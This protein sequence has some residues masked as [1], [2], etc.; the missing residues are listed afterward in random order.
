MR[1]GVAAPCVSICV[2]TYNFGRYLGS[3]IRSVLEQT[4]A[5]W[6]LIVCDNASTDDSEAVASQWRDPRIRY[7]RYR[8]T[9]PMIHNFNRCL[10]RV[11]GEYVLF[12]CADDALMPT[13]IARLVDALRCHPTA[14][15]AVA[16]RRQDIDDAGEPV[17][18]L[19][20]H[21]LGPGLVRGEEVLAAQCREWVT[22]GLP[23]QVLARTSAVLACGGLDP[24]AT[25]SADNDLFSRICITWDAVYVDEATFLY[26]QHDA[27]ATRRHRRLL[28]DIRS[29]SYVFA[30]LFREAPSLRGNRE[31][32]RAF[33]RRVHPWFRR[34]VESLRHGDLRTAAWILARFAAFEPVP[35][36][37]PYHSYRYARHT[38]SRLVRGRAGAARTRATSR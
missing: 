27:M 23:P 8:I 32:R 13:T 21:R 15:V 3:A 37:L 2:P 12:L 33:V 19:T 36:W 26:R 20:M 25:Q 17:G 16:R 4:F 11:R 7:H 24:D 28:E 30:K 29:E 35:W 14:G 5:D 38:V 9:V 34:A 31:L 22:V 10:E 18:P 6:E 1:R